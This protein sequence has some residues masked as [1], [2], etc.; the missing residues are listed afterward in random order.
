MIRTLLSNDTQNVIAALNKS[1]AIIEFDLKGQ[2]LTANDHFCNAVGYELSEIKGKHHS[3][4]VDP[5]EVSS[6]G[7]K[8]FW[9][10]LGEGQ[11]DR[12]Q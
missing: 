4:F 5:A 8:A 1:M 11:F 3:I 12:A 9:K 10:R 7:Y 6:E 2:I